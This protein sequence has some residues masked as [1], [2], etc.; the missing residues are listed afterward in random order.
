MSLLLLVMGNVKAVI[1][2]VGAEYTVQIEL[3]LQ[4]FSILHSLKPWWGEYFPT[5]L[6]LHVTS[7]WTRIDGICLPN[8]EH[9]AQSCELYCSIRFYAIGGFKC[10]CVVVLPHIDLLLLWEV[11]TLTTADWGRRKNVHGAGT[12]F[13]AKPSWVQRCWSTL[14]PFAEK[15]GSSFL[16]F[17]R[18]EVLN[19][20]LYRIFVATA[21]GNSHQL[22]F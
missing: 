17:Q 11:M 1:K 10:I 19:K 9:Q 8:S 16:S 3:R 2:L 22:M 7:H 12:D 15:W 18:V 21:K 5:P 14:S 6:T 13:R 4:K 20:L